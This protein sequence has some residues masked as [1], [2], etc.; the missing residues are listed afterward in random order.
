MQT[1]ANKI[2]I[3]N[4]LILQ[5]KQTKQLTAVLYFTE[6]FKIICMK[7]CEPLQGDFSK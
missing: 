1:S 7:I 4:L 3:C 5:P 2:N 6:I